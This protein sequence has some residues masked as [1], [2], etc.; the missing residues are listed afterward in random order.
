[1]KIRF[2]WYFKFN[3]SGIRACK[4]DTQPL[5]LC[6]LLSGTFFFLQFGATVFIL[7]SYSKDAMLL[8]AKRIDSSVFPLAGLNKIYLFIALNRQGLVM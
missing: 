6:S 8:P 2:A 3:N 5:E 4:A 7:L 1:M